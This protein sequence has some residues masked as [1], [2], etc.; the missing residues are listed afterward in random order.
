[1]NAARQILDVNTTD[2]IREYL[3][4]S[5]VPQS[6]MTVFG[7]SLRSRYVVVLVYI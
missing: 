7:L 2:V 4:F 6:P 1:M 3:I 5:S